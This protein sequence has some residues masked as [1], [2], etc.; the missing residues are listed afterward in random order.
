M[1]S[2]LLLSL[3]PPPSSLLPPPSSLL[4]PPSSLLPPP[5]SLLPPPSS[6]LPP[7]SSLLPPPS[8]LLPPPSSLLPPPL[9]HSLPSSFQGVR[10]RA[11]FSLESL[12]A[13][14]Y[15]FSQPGAL[16]G[17][18]NYQRSMFLRRN[19]DGWKAPATPI[20]VPVLII[21]VCC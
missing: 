9:P 5:S 15:T 10:N 6:L 8:S 1:P 11:A 13:Y 2:L 7:P 18:C 4:P 14:K 19:R 3:L 16:T 17:P 20:E 21:W 12:E